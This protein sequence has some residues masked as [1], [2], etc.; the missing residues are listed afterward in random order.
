MPPSNNAL[1]RYATLDECLQRRARRWTFA[2]LQAAVAERLDAQLGNGGKV[3]VRTL[4][5]T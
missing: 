5:G 4:R 1:L 3:S 2:D